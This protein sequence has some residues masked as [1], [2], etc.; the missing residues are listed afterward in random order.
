MPTNKK[1]QSAIVAHKT[2]IGNKADPC[3]TDFLPQKDEITFSIRP[4]YPN[5]DR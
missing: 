1:G 5:N 2:N 3:Q 4:P